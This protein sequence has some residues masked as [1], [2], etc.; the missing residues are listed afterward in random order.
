MLAGREHHFYDMGVEKYT[1]EG[2]KC[3]VNKRGKGIHTVQYRLL[4]HASHSFWPFDL[5]QRAYSSAVSNGGNQRS[6]AW[7]LPAPSQC[8]YAYPCQP[9]VRPRHRLHFIKS[10]KTKKKKRKRDKGWRWRCTFSSGQFGAQP[11]ERRLDKTPGGGNRKI[12]G[13]AMRKKRG[14]G[15]LPAKSCRQHSRPT[16]ESEIAKRIVTMPV[17]TLIQ[18]RRPAQIRRTGRGTCPRAATDDVGKQHHH[19]GHIRVAGTRNC[20]QAQ[21]QARAHSIVTVTVHRH[22]HTAHGPGSATSVHA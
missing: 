1:G 22:R 11:A 4:C 15:Q 14:L 3:I 9:T 6:P 12:R 5:R 16:Q 8:A 20:A 7:A 2:T 19:G 10:E 21:A 17:H 13:T 18:Y